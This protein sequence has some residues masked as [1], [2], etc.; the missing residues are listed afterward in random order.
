MPMSLRRVYMCLDEQ[1]D[2]SLFA[3][4]GSTWHPGNLATLATSGAQALSVYYPRP[5]Y[6]YRTYIFMLTDVSKTSV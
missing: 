3:L 6:V 4:R 5:R 2:G 1:I